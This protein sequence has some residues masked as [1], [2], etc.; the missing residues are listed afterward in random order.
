MFVSCRLIGLAPGDVLLVKG[1]GIVECEGNFTALGKDI[2]NNVSVRAGKV[3]PFETN[4]GGT[5][6]VR[7]RRHGSV[8]TVRHGKVGVSIWKDVAE[9]MHEKPKRVMLVG[10]TDTGKS[11]LTTYL[12]NLLYASGRRIAV[13]DGDVG[14]G[15]LA[16]PG[17]IGAV[18]IKEQFLDLRDL[19]ADSLRFI[20]SISPMGIE[21]LII[22]KLDDLITKM[23]VQSDA[24]LINTDG[25]IDEGGIDYKIA[26]AETIKP[27]LVVCLGRSFHGFEKF[28]TVSVD[29]P[30][31]ITKTR[32]EREARRLCQ[33]ARFLDGKTKSLVVKVKRLAFM[34]NFYDHSIIADGLAR[35]RGALIPSSALRG[36]FVGLAVGDDVKGFGIIRRMI[37]GKIIIRTPCREKFDTI[38][39]SIIG[40]SRDMRN[41]YRIPLVIKRQQ[42]SEGSSPPE[43][44]RPC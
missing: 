37:D 33:Y 13:V 29:L 23:A 11:T 14:Q 42:R 19:Q 17:C 40:I 44:Y 30:S 9:K 3:L 2:R 15:D 1:P 43:S 7:V 27:D 31:K 8:I 39:L 12:S 26:L 35:I 28:E 36:M 16:P 4:E 32:G 21:N 38:M 41:E 18:L 10:A 25:Y 22:D 5:A 6:R 34:G 20:G 24:C